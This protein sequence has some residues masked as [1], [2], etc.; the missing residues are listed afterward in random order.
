[1]VMD[2]LVWGIRAAFWLI[3]VFYGF[4]SVS[5][6]AEGVCTKFSNPLL[7]QVFWIADLSKFSLHM[8]VVFRLLLLHI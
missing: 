5:G 6:N 4:S 3:L 2:R 8:D 7:L 1:M